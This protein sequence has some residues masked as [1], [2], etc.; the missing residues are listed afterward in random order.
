MSAIIE[1]ELISSP[2]LVPRV[3]DLPPLTHKQSSFVFNYLDADNPKTFRNGTQS[4]IAAGYT[5]NP[6]VANAIAG[7]NLRK[8]SIQAHIQHALKQRHI[9]S[10]EVIAEFSDIALLPAN[11]LQSLANP[12]SPYNANH[13]LKALELSAKLLGLD[14]P[15]DDDIPLKQVLGDVCVLFREAAERARAH[16]A[17]QAQ[18]SANATDTTT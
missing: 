15:T 11:R 10:D 5:D 8:P 6:E 12:D 1:A 7:E 18:L 16:Q 13:K 4:A 3:E 9:S 2:M 17:Q 14:R